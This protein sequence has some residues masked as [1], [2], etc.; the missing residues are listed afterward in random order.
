MQILNEHP[1]IS[2]NGALWVVFLKNSHWTAFTDSGHLFSSAHPLSTFY[3]DPK[4]VH[5][6]DASADS[7]PMGRLRSRATRTT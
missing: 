1:G 4:H 2:P 7:Q 5:L 3:T 6:S